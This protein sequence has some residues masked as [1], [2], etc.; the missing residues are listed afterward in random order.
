L[1]AGPIAAVA[2]GTAL[3]GTTALFGGNPLPFALQVLGGALAT[4]FLCSVPATLVAMIP[5]PSVRSTA[6]VVVL[7]A[8]AAGVTAPTALAARQT[9]VPGPPPAGSEAGNGAQLPTDEMEVP[10]ELY[11][12]VVVRPLREGRLASSAAA[13]RLQTERPPLPEYA[14]RIRTEVLPT[15]QRMADTA[16]SVRIDDERTRT[17]HQHAVRASTLHLLGYE[18]I[19]EAMEQ[20]SRALQ[21]DGNARLAEGNLEWDQ[22]AAG[23]ETL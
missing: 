18:L 20:N 22:W 10:R 2:V 9:L 6:V 21:L 17:V 14:A 15:L 19:A 5:V 4:G 11:R 13:T 23:V 8:I 12:D 16:G 7:A 1:L 3:L